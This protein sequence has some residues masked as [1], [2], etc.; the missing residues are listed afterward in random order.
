M[1]APLQSLSERA[2][3]LLLGSGAHLRIRAAHSFLALLA[4]GLF[5]L[6]QWQGVR[7]GVMDAQ[8]RRRTWPST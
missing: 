8:A 2:F 7:L 1:D 3:A 6:C 4:Y 5:A